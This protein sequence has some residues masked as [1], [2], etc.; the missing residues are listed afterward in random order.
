MV[1]K[2]RE[3]EKIDLFMLCLDGLNPRLADYTKATILL[4]R[5]IFPEF[6]SHSVIVFNKWGQDKWANENSLTNLRDNY[7]EVF[8]RQ[9][10]QPSIATSRCFKCLPASQLPSSGTGGSPRAVRL[11]NCLLEIIDTAQLII[12]TH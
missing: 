7:Q 2:I 11:V 6:L 10:Q 5:D 4:F 8:Q 12:I 3:L 1:E 9:Y